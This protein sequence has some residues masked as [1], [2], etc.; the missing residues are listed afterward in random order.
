MSE[1][2]NRLIT[3]TSQQSKPFI[4]V[5]AGLGAIVA[6]FYAQMHELY[7]NHLIL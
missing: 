6:R 1:D 3:A 5:G 2:L 4:L 7:V